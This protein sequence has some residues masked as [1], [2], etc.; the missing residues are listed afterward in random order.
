MGS[1]QHYDVSNWNLW[2]VGFNIILSLIGPEGTV[3]VIRAVG[4]LLRKKLTVNGP[5][6]V[7]VATEK[8]DKK[9]RK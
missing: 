7:A 3:A 1:Y 2:L 8:E 4:R 9:K 5:R 6:N